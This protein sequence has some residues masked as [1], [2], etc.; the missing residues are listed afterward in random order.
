MAKVLA[1]EVAPF[2][3]RVLTVVLGTFD[4]GML[5]KIATSKNPMPVDYQGSVADQTIQMLT[6][7][8]F[9]PDGDKDKAMNAV[10]D[11]VTGEGVG[12]GR[13]G[14]RLLPLGRDMTARVKLVQ[15]QLAHSLEVFGEVCNSVYRD[16]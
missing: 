15:E 7:G 1:K 12:A 13:E 6:S 16:A 11:V 3:I 8:V 5:G 9:K 14:E 4:T 10:Y 2:N